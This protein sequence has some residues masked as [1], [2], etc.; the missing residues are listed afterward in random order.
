MTFKKLSYYLSDAKI[1]MKCNHAPVCKFLITHT[2]NFKVNKEETENGKVR[3]L[4]FE[5]NQRNRNFFGDHIS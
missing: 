3:H 5:T 1:M 4:T 2:L